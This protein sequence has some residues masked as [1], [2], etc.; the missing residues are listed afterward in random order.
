MI[1]IKSV[2]K[3]CLTVTLWHNATQERGFMKEKKSI[4][5][6]QEALLK[7]LRMRKEVLGHGISNTSAVIEKCVELAD[8]NQVIKGMKK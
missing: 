8:E 5:I 1:I 4:T 6:S 3:A 7:I 2:K